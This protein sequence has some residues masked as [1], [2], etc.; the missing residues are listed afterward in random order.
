MTV[1]LAPIR[2]PTGAK[3]SGYQDMGQ[4]VLPNSGLEVTYSKRLYRFNEDHRDAL[5][6]MVNIEVSIDDYITGNDSQ[7]RWVL[8]QINNKHAIDNTKVLMI[9][10]ISC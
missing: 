10:T 6:P 1:T 2:T 3:P 9:C 5:Y 7:L 8:K 4:F